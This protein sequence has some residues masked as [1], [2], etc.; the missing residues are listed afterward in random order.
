MSL[1]GLLNVLV[2]C[3][4]VVLQYVKNCSYQVSFFFVWQISKTFK[5]YEIINFKLMYVLTINNIFIEVKYYLYY[6]YIC[7]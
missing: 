6:I 4:Y 7:K 5:Y 2:M 1:V 3:I